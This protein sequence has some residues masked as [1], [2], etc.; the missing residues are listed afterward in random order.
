V[1]AFGREST[2]NPISLVDDMTREYTLAAIPG[3]GIG[4]EVIPA[5][6]DVLAAIAG[7]EGFELHV[8]H[9]DWDSERYLRTGEYIPAGGLEALKTFD[10]ILVMTNG[11]PGFVTETL[12]IYIY[13]TAF[14]YQQIGYSSALLV[15]FFLLVLL[16]SSSVLSL[17]RS[18][19]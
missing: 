2:I 10:I 16:L 7:L 9:F 4:K 1:L 13:N 19:A 11:G 3:D 8:E 17:R 15:V 18:R 5:G 14:Q 12:N 6:L